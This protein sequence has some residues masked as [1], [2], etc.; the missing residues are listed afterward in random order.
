MVIFHKLFKCSALELCAVW[1]RCKSYA[2]ME[3]DEIVT[4]ASAS[5]STIIIP[6]AGRGTRMHPATQVTAK[7]LLPV[8]DRLVIEFAID[9]AIEAG[10]ERIVVVVSD[11]KP[12]I[13]EFLG[14]TANRITTHAGGAAASPQIVYVMQSKPLGLGH[15]VLCCKGSILPGP[16]GVLL[17]DDV[18]LGRSC[19]PEMARNYPGDHMI[20]AIRVPEQETCNYGIFSLGGSANGQCI[21]V[22]GM[23]EKPPRGQAPSSIAAVGRYILQPMIFDVLAQ[24]AKG[25]GGELQLTDAIEVATRSV[26]LTAFQFSGTRYD[27]GTHDGLLAA[28]NARQAAV[29]AGRIKDQLSI[30]RFPGSADKTSNIDGPVG[31]GLRGDPAR[32]AV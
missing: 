22:K 2:F 20:A 4:L 16:F 6:A 21:P 15:A 10:A 32:H 18:I 9:E 27:C 23:V 3:G 14:N 29:R 7:E 24:T 31:T 30:A 8:Y 19:L 12:S 25:A 13:R 1:P 11:E 28:A 5:I 26:P 17:P